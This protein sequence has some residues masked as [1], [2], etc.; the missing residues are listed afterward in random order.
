MQSKTFTYYLAIV[1]TCFGLIMVGDVKA[2]GTNVTWDGSTSSDWDIGSNWSTGTVPGVDFLDGNVTIPSGLGNYP[3]VNNARTV[4]RLVALESG[5]ISGS[6]NITITNASTM[7][8]TGTSSISCNLTLNVA[9]GF[10][11]T[12]I[13]D[14]LAIT[15]NVSGNFALTLTGSG[16]GLFS[17]IRSG[18]STIDKTGTGTWTVSGINTHSGATTV[19]AGTLKLGSAGSGSNGPLGTIG[20]STTI[21]G[22][23]TLDLN[24]FT[25]VTAEP[26]SLTGSGTSNSGALTNTGG[27]ASYSGAITLAGATTIAATT[28]GTLTLS[29]NI[30]SAQTLTLRGDGNGELSGVRSSGSGIVKND[31]GTWTLSNTNTYTGA[32]TVTLGTLRAGASTTVFGGASP[33]TVSDGGT[34]DLNGFNVTLGSTLAVNGGTTG[35]TVSTGSGILTLSNNVTSTGGTN[36]LISGNLALGANRTFT[37]NTPA[38]L[39][40]SAVVSGAFNLI[41]AGTGGLLLSGNNTYTGVTSITGTLLL[42]ATGNGTN[43]PLGTVAGGVTIA[44]SST[45]DLNGFTLSTAEAITS[46]QGTGF[47]TIGAITNTGGNASYSGNITL[48]N[49]TTFEATTSGTLTLSGDISGNS[50]LTL[51]GDGDGTLSGVRSGTS[52]IIKN[53]AGTWT[54]SGENSYTGATTI[55]LGTLKLGAAGNGVNTPLGTSAGN[56]TIAAGAALDLNGFTLSTTENITSITGD[57]VSSGGAITNTG[58]NASYSGALT[59]SGATTIVATTSGTLT[60]S[61]NIT[62]NQILTLRGAGDGVYSGIR[63]GS[64]ALVKDDGG[65]WTLSND[66]TYSGVTTITSGTL[67]LGANGGATNTPLGTT[68]G[69]TTI[70]AGGALDL[71]GFTLGTAEGIT[72]MAGTGVSGGGAITNTGG[73]AS[74]SGAIVLVTPGAS[75]KTTTSGT[76]TVSGGISGNFPL[77]LNGDGTGT[78]SG[79]RSGTSTIVKDG[80]GDWTLSNIGSTYSGETTI[81]LGTLKLGS[82]GGATNTPLGTNVGSTT[83]ASGGALDLNGFTLGTAEAITSMAGTGVSGGGAITNTGGNA[84]YSGAITLVT[85]GASIES[86][87]SGTIT[88]S[89]AIGGNFP[90][91]LDGNGTG[92]YSGV[93]S[94]TSTIVKEGTGDWTLSNVGSTYSGATTIN[95]GTLRLGSAGGATNTPLGTIATGTTVNTGAVLDLNG[96]TLGTAEGLT[97]NGTGLAASPAGA[98][99]NTGGNASY[100]GAITL[101]SAATITSTTLGTLTCSGTVGTGAFGLTLDGASTTNGTMSG[102]ISTPTSLTKNGAGTWTLSGANSYTGAT[103]ISSGILRL[104]A[105]GV[106]PDA[107]AL[108]VAGTFDLNGFSETVGSI[109][110][111]GSITSSAAGTLT[112]TAG[113]DNTSTT[114][115]G[116]ISNGS[117]TSVALVKNGSGALTLSTS[118][119]YT[120]GTTLNAGTL[121]I[122]HASALGASGTFTIAGGSIDNTSGADITTN[123]YTLSLNADFTYTGSIPRNLNLGTGAVTM[124]ASRQFTVNAGTLTIG[125]VINNSTQNITKAGAGTLSFGSQAVTVNNVSINAGTLVSTSNTLGIAGNF[126]NSGTFTHNSGT[127]DFNASGA[128]NIAGVTYHSLTC[129]NSG[130]KTATGNLVI[131]GTLTIGASNILDMTSSFTL[132]GTLGTIANSGTI[133][134]SVPTTTSATPLA[135]GKTWNGLVNYAATTGLQTIAAGTY[136]NVTMSHTTDSNT[137]NGSVTIGGVL[138]LSGGKLQIGANTLTLNGTTSGMTGSSSLSSNGASSLTIGGSGALGTNLFLSQTQPGTTNRLVNLTYNRSGA[139]G[140]NAIT[141]GNALQVT[142]NLTPTAG[143]LASG[144]N[145]TLISNASGTANI[146]NGGCTTCSYITGNVNIQRFIPSVARRFRF[147]GSTVQSTTLD[148]W[149]DEIYI[150]G[151]GGASNG[152]DATSTNSPSVYW[153][154]ETMITGNLNTGWTAATNT[155]NNLVVGRGYRVFV[156]GDRSDIGRLT[157]T[158]NDQNAVT[159]DLVGVPNQGNI[160]IPL[161]LTNSASGGTVYDPANDGWN[162]VSNPYACGYNWNAHYDDSTT[163]ANI[164]PVIWS[165][166]GQSGGYVSYSAFADAGSLTSGIIPGG[167]SFWVKANNTGVPT[168]TFKEQ[169]KTTN[170]PLGLFKTNEGESFKMRLYFDSITYDDAIVKYITGSTVNYDDFDIR[171]LAGTVTLS[172]YGNDNVHLDLSSRPVSLTNDTIKL[173]VSGAVGSYKLL[174][175]NSNEIAVAENVFLFDTYLSTITDLKDTSV[176]PF[177]ILSGVPASSGL[178]RFYIVISNDASLPVKLLQFNAR[179]TSNKQVQLNWSTAQETNS[180]TFEVERS[181]DGKNYITIASVAAGGN[182]NKLINYS[183]LDEQPLRSNYY[184]LKQVDLDGTFSYSSVQYVLLEEIAGA[185]LYPIPAIKTLTIEHTQPL[186]G[187]TIMDIT[188]H[189][190]LSQKGGNTKIT[191]DVSGLQTGVYVL[192]YTDETGTVVKEKFTKQ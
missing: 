54:L 175:N 30:S 143:E 40:I 169:Y 34:L 121:N 62:N 75:I 26:I 21:S 124:S 67:K 112:L 192:E 133:R 20:G 170:A 48:A 19:S 158:L 167:A 183:A 72:S 160:A 118:N 168:L 80:T 131:D 93:R 150:T 37:I 56:V 71:N 57:G 97:L 149:Q 135:S 115:S 100:S 15:G 76:L 173:Y 12:S 44:A 127:V 156:R 36:A 33:M 5:S 50:A 126:T 107:S 6:G 70:A 83:I 116:A 49:T 52:T 66:N 4:R 69:G 109:S 165:L 157:G 145:L 164:Q 185:K 77:T 153:Y 38:Q 108:S 166:S 17:G 140:G 85:P 22:T 117:A 65:T 31:A 96:F 129:S 132:Q 102:A 182:T 8:S 190:I 3:V 23:G 119:S 90:L 99:T 53:D 178:N 81:T 184:R 88:I 181:S 84:S 155:T 59:L 188:G 68:A 2:G 130:T 162:M 134:T 105:A 98:L 45:L 111:A 142:E 18:T 137:M 25:L 174:F 29:S 79:V 43:T 163:H 104:G 32:T 186:V 35:G 11:P 151:S 128:Q 47:S 144:G 147:I 125:G 123:N 28:S 92:T 13:G 63:S 110:G 106:V 189:I 55:T 1:L 154:D 42:G 46:V 41:K 146:A 176:Y 74:Y 159:M 78:Y 73:S 141:L 10:S 24:G 86:T 101:G 152:F 136:N 51:R 187:V 191:I 148:D 177:S 39:N 103:T 9:Y 16:N 27:N 161:S 172:V 138:T 91:T 61:G 82:A 87:T 171:K 14:S 94:G 180:K 122:N 7:T 95:G 114:F 60:L 120:G 139:T 179:K 64:S 113:G 89:G 58:G